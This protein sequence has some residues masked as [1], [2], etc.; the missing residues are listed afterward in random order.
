MTPLLQ[1]QHLQLMINQ[2]ML[3]QDLNLTIQAGQCWAILG[4]NGVGKTTLLHALAGLHPPQKGVVLLNGHPIDRLS[5]RQVAQELGVLFQSEEKNFPATVLET[6]LMGRHPHLSLWERESNHDHHLA[7]QAL[8]Q[9]GLANFENRPVHT[10]SGGEQR[11]LD[12]AVLLTQNPNLFLLDEPTNH[13]DFSYSL[14]ILNT[15]CQQTKSHK[16]AVIMILHDINL[17]VRFCDFFLFLFGEGKMHIGSAQE[18]LTEPL[19]ERLYGHPLREVRYS[20]RSIW[21]AE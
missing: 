16:K 13:L 7:C 3:L 14:S 18:M 19:L 2:Q 4:R 8:A 12:V 11:R 15:I 20:G 1:T 21:V 6:A 10:L 17:A 5:R 9:V